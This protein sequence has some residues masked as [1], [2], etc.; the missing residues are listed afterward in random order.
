MTKHLVHK[1]KK[2]WGGVCTY[3]AF[4]NIHQK[5]I[6]T[7]TVHTRELNVSFLYTPV[8]VPVGHRKTKYTSSSHQAPA[9]QSSY[10]CIHI[11]T[12]TVLKENYV[13]GLKCG[14]N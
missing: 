5:Y 10:D 6:I 4:K 11:A 2:S 3:H 13:M 7:H 9:I 1:K 14:N 8:C 12:K